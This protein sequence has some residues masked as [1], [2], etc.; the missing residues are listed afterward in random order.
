MPSNALPTNTD[1]YANKVTVHNNHNKSTEIIHSSTEII[2]IGE[3]HKKGISLLAVKELL[4][5]KQP[6]FL[7]KNKF[8]ENT[9][10]F[11]FSTYLLADFN[12]RST[13]ILSPY[14][15]TISD[16]T[17]SKAGYSFGVTM[18]LTHRSGLL[19][20]IGIER[21]KTFEKFRI[22]NILTS[23]ERSVNDN[24]FSL[25]GEFLSREVETTKTIRQ[26]ALVYNTYLQTNI[27]PFIGYQK[28]GKINYTIS[29]SPIFN[30]N[31]TYNGYLID[32]SDLLT[33]NVNDLYQSTKLSYNGYALGAIAS[34]RIWRKLYLG[35]RAQVKQTKTLTSET[36]VDFQTRLKSYSIGL[37]L[38]YAIH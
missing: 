10:L 36:N 17:A 14:G 4:L 13:N 22:N 9:L 28:T 29:I 11:N 12:Q 30:L 21:V 27:L 38:N 25:N 8:T 32:K 23:L 3:L 18:S 26:D 24:A 33:T 37:D 19:G 35:I 1:N 20:G 34:K 7:L 15:Q 2:N 5:T 6:E 31:R 16:L